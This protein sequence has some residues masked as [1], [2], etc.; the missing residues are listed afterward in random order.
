L[1]ALGTAA[2]RSKAE[3]LRGLA[4]RL[5]D[6]ALPAV[7][8]MTTPRAWAHTLIGIMEFMRRFFGHR[9]AADVRLDLAE[10]LLDMY[11]KHRSDDDQWFWFE[12]S[13]SYENAKLPHALI[14]C[15]QW[16]DRGDMAGA[17]LE[18]LKWLMDVQRMEHGHFVPIGTHGHYSRGGRR[19]RFDQQPIE[20]QASLSACLEAHRMTQEPYWRKEAERAFDWFLGGN[21]LGIPLYNPRTGGCYDGICRDRINQ[22]QGAEATVSYLLSRM[23]MEFAEHLIV[24]SKPDD[25]EPEKSEDAEH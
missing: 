25:S 3:G 23:E 7:E 12:D 16:L 15:G 2:G 20:A 8:A 6:E 17:G 5:F 13:L 24:D 9:T 11:Q 21:D 19:S 18:S 1:W 4:G 10:R 22:N 14:L